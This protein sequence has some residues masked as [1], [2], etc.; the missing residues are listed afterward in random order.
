MNK[1][2]I[3]I[4]IIIITTIKIIIIKTLCPLFMDRVQLPEGQNHFEAAVNLLPLNS[5]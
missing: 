3:I 4:I 2:I 5:Q 1:Q